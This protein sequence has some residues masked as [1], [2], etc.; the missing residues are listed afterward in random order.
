MAKDR[1]P[2]KPAGSPASDKA[3]ALGQEPPK[4]GAQLDRRQK[5]NTALTEEAMRNPTGGAHSGTPDP[6][7]A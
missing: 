1:T 5:R 2:T 3:A 6:T 7:N 4:A